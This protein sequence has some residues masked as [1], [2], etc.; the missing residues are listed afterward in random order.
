VCVTRPLE[1]DTLR[2]TLSARWNGAI[3]V[4]EDAA[5]IDAAL[6]VVS[7]RKVRERLKADES[8]DHLVGSKIAE[9]CAANKIGIK[10]SGL[11][12]ALSS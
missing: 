9:Y 6:D 1:S 12:A 2:A 4:V 10:V 3:F 11:S 8:V 5:V 7:S